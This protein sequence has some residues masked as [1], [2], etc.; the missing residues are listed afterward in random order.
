MQF[1]N[2]W[3]PVIGGLLWKET[4]IFLLFLPHFSW[5]QI[6]FEIDPSSEI[7][8]N[9]TSSLHDWVSTVNKIVGGV[10]IN[11][12]G[13]EIPD[14]QDLNVTIPVTAIKSGKKSMDKNTCEALQST[15]HPE[16]KY[17]LT[18][19]DVQPENVL[20][21]TGKL[22]NSGYFKISPNAGKLQYPLP[23]KGSI[24]GRN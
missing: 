18:Q 13:E 8:V 12:S 21:T 1:S 2:T 9:G 14:I 24:H 5:S 17:V 7:T 19:Y 23:G 16:I 4:T 20:N 6:A 15:E 10:N 22:Q 11:L 3:M